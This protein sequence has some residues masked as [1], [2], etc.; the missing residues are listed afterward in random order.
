[1]S[2]PSIPGLLNSDKAGI[3][4]TFIGGKGTNTGYTMWKA[5]LM[6][7]IRVKPGLRKIFADLKSKARIL[8]DLSDDEK[9]SDEA[10]AMEAV[11]AKYV[12]GEAA[13]VMSSAKPSEEESDL[14]TSLSAL[15]SEYFSC[16][17]MSTCF[18]A[19]TKLV[20]SQ[21][22]QA[23]SPADFV[24][25]KRP[26]LQNQLDGEISSDEVLVASVSVGSGSKYSGVI[27]P[28]F[29]DG[30]KA[31]S[32]SVNKIKCVLIEFDV[33]SSGFQQED[34]SANL[35]GSS[36]NNPLKSTTSGNTSEAIL[37]RQSAE[38]CL[39]N[40]AKTKKFNVKFRQADQRGKGEKGKPGGGKPKEKGDIPTCSHC[41]VRG[42]GPGKCFYLHPELA[43]TG[44]TS[45]GPAH[46]A[47]SSGTGTSPQPAV[48][49]VMLNQAVHQE[50]VEGHRAEESRVDGSGI[51]IDES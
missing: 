6:K 37:R 43:A 7:Q 32:D 26:V 14:F 39:A 27:A 19:L 44:W 40:L 20:G 36:R 11:L 23:E 4:D 34:P 15:D 50:S 42:H 3:L 5:V 35:A 30:S 17:I 8:A 45:R 16:T 41:G 22:R 2:A 24:V 21:L 47:L 13:R 18:Q 38:A 51:I 49:H 1:M 46:S 28:L 10:I 12:K 25:R 31:S 29:V 9:F 48:N 33:V